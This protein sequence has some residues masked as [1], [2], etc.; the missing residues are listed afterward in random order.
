VNNYKIEFFCLCP[1]NG[2]RIKYE[3]V[4]TVCSNTVIQV[5]DLLQEVS[6]FKSFYHEDLANVLYAKFGGKQ[7]LTAD[8]HGV[9][10][11]TTRGD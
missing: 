10:L 1:K 11:Q 4:I 5:E 3:L 8:H 9:T 2:I 6:N 7:T